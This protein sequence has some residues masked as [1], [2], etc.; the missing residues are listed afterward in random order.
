MPGNGRIE[1]KYDGDHDVFLSDV[2][3]ASATDI[4][5]KANTNLGNVD[6]NLT[7]DEK[8]GFRDKVGA[9]AESD[10]PDGG[11]IWLEAADVSKSGDNFTLSPDPSITELTAGLTFSWRLTA[12]NNGAVGVIVSSLS[13]VGVRKSDNS[14]FASGELPSDGKIEIIYDADQNLF[15]SDVDPAGVTDISGK[16]NTNLQNILDTLTASQQD[17]VQS[18]LNVQRQL[19]VHSQNFR[20]APTTGRY[21]A[22]SGNPNSIISAK[23]AHDS[24]IGLAETD[25]TVDFDHNNLRGNFYIANDVYSHNNNAGWQ[26][27]Y[28]NVAA[29]DIHILPTDDTPPL[30]HRGRVGTGETGGKRSRRPREFAPDHPET[31]SMGT[32]Y[33]PLDRR[34]DPHIL[35]GS[36]AAR[37]RKSW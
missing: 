17:T 29:Y 27:T 23:L 35:R 3:P 31:G 33:L 28:V 15:I 19:A 22:S 8:S 4:S 24:E 36:A 26:F 5:G 1:I 18:R 32:T 10:I 11:A 2:D 21:V 13:P 30:C 12:S 14:Q 37:G 16:A 20:N 9:I 6:E 7:D 34:H 25:G